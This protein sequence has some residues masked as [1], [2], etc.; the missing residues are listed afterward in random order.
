MGCVLYE[1][2]TGSPPF[3]RNGLL[4][5]PEYRDLAKRGQGDDMFAA[6]AASVA[7]LVFPERVSKWVHLAVS[8]CMKGAGGKAVEKEEGQGEGAWHAPG[9]CWEG[10]CA[11]APLDSGS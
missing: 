9:F 7:G 5:S 2:L 8:K 11:G 6:A 4:G 10:K 1:L 3:G